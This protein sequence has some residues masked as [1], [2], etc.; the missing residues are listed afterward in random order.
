MMFQSRACPPRCGGNLGVRVFDAHKNATHWICSNGYCLDRDAF[1]GERIDERPLRRSQIVKSD[2]RDRIG[3]A[4]V[5][6]LN[7]MSKCLFERR[8]WEQPINSAAAFKLCRP[9]LESCCLDVAPG[10]L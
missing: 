3:Q 10:A 8:W 6:G 5:T 1:T 2:Q 7:K 4:N 9:S